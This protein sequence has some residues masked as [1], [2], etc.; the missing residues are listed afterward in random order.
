[1][2][3][4]AGYLNDRPSLEEL[5]IRVGSLGLAGYIRKPL[6]PG[7][8]MMLVDEMIGVSCAPHQSPPK[9]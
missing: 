7:Y 5:E 3:G 2:A 8:V 6:A 4:D 9:Q 1:M